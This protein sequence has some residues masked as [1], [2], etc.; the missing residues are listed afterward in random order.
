VIAELLPV[1]QETPSAA[2]WGFTVV[3]YLPAQ[4]TYKRAGIHKLLSLYPL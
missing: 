1:V 3:L 4:A 2:A